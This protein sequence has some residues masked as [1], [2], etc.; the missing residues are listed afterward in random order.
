MQVWESPKDFFFV[1]RVTNLFPIGSE[2]CLL[3]MREYMLGNADQ[4]N[5]LHLGRSHVLWQNLQLM[6]FRMNMQ[7]RYLWLYPYTCISWPWSEKSVLAVDD[8]QNGTHL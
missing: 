6:F 8:G 4:A 7:L 2:A 3:S 5:N 1:L